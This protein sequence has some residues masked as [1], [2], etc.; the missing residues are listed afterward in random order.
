VKSLARTPQS[1]SFI[2][3]NHRFQFTQSELEFLAQRVRSVI[4]I[5]LGEWFL[6]QSLGIP[7]IPKTDMKTGHRAILET[8]LR[9]KITAIKGIKKLIYVNSVYQPKGR[10]LYIDFAAETDK[11]ETLEMKETQTTP[12]PGGSK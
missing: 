10:E 7:Y 12:V 2:R 6:D 5:F 9:T 4:S 1:N 11:G 8:A 3:K